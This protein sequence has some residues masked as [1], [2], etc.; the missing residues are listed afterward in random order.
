MRTEKLSEA[1]AE[2][3]SADT[4]SR[5]T[6]QGC[7]EIPRSPRGEGKKPQN[8]P[9]SAP[10]P[11]GAIFMFVYLALRCHREWGGRRA[12]LE[13]TMRVTA[14]GLPKHLSRSCKSS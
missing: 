14:W 12:S 7:S 10:Q 8:V 9:E 2:V 4:I 6:T 1:K 11:N 13:P 5:S 3:A